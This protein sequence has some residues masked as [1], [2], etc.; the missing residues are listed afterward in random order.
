MKKKKTEWFP[1]HEYTPLY[2][3]PGWYE[4]LYEGVRPERNW[5]NGQAWM[6]HPKANAWDSWRGFEGD[7][8]RGIAG[9]YW[10]K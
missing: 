9:Y 6:L 7:Y 1:A 5:W 2:S 10:G 8:W 4:Y 3:R